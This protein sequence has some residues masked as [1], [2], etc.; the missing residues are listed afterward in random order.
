LCCSFLLS[1]QVQPPFLCSSRYFNFVVC[2][3]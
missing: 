3:I 2:S 1:N